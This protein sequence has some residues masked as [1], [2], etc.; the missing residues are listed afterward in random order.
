M[1]NKLKIIKHILKLKQIKKLQKNKQKKNGG[2]FEIKKKQKYLQENLA[3]ES[4]KD[5]EDNGRRREWEKFIKLLKD[6][7]NQNKS[8]L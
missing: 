3:N 5:A 1:Y 2:K 7:R 6:G 4:Q 8:K